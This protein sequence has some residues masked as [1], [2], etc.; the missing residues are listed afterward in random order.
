MTLDDL[1]ALDAAATPGPWEVDETWPDDVVIYTAEDK[2]W[3]V[4][5]GNWSRQ[6]APDTHPADSDYL[7][8]AFEADAN[9]AA[10]IAA[11]R[12]A[13]PALLAI[14][15]ALPEDPWRYSAIWGA[16]ECFS[17]T[18]L[19]SYEAIRTAVDPVTLHW[20]GCRWLAARAALAT[21]EDR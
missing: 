3:V 19:A 2:R 12:N 6:S 11:A 16:K 4:N 15:E 9:D 21:L 8:N 13:L 1:R 14:A 10:L 7:R 18:H 20:P 17:C 5:V